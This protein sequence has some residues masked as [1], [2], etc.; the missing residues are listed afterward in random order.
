MADSFR[1]IANVISQLNE[2]AGQIGNIVSTIS[3][4]ADQTNL[5]ALNAAIEYR[6][7]K[8]RRTR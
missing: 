7:D 8:S 1:H 6:S 4:V 3:G 2:R 5:L